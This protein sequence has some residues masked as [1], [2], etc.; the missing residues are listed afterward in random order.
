MM[1]KSFKISFERKKKGLKELKEEEAS[2]F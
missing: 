1:L 2:F